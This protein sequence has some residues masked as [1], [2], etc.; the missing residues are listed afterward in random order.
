MSLHWAGKRYKFPSHKRQS[1]R[2]MVGKKE[3]M[4]YNPARYCSLWK[5]ITDESSREPSFP[6]L[7]ESRARANDIE[8]GE[9]LRKESMIP[10]SSSN[11]QNDVVESFSPASSSR[12]RISHWHSSSRLVKWTFFVRNFKSWLVGSV[13]NVLRRESFKWKFM[14]NRKSS[15]VNVDSFVIFFHPAVIKVGGIKIDWHSHS[16]IKHSRCFVRFGRNF[17]SFSC[18]TATTTSDRN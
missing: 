7:H 14:Q 2:R 10:N 18:G 17:S 8:S 1:K 3:L 16:F 5:F 13:I 11:Q 4:L 12:M 15:R 6:S 9:S